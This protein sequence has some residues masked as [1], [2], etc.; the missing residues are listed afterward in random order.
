MNKQIKDSKI[1]LATFE[2]ASLA[3]FVP[4]K[5]G[6]FRLC[7]EYCHLN[8]ITVE[9]TYTLS[10]TNE[11]IVSLVA[12]NIFNTLNANS[13]YW[14]NLVKE[15][16]RDKSDF[17]CDAGLNRNKRMPFGLTHA[18][19]LLQLALNVNL[20]RFKQKHACYTLMT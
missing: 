5:D 13:G 17:V 2:L 14:Q 9:D 3:S 16:D 15:E 20:S 18:P 11:C 1:E 19:A 12:S 4:K 10:R 6:S 7:I 8:K